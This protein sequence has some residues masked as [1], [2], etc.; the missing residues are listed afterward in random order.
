MR[1]ILVLYDE[2]FL[3]KVMKTHSMSDQPSLVA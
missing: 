3:R 2:I 1:P